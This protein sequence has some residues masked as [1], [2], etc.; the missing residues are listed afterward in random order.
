MS[1][2]F[3]KKH[4]LFI[5]KLKSLSSAFYVIV[6]VGSNTHTKKQQHKNTIKLIIMKKNQIITTNGGLSKMKLNINNIKYHKITKQCKVNVES[7]ISIST[8]GLVVFLNKLLTTNNQT[9][10]YNQ[11][12]S[13][14]QPIKL[15]FTTNQT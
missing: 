13:S 11:S 15:L 7:N 4:T 5:N 2:F 3:L 6:E 14:L 1:N 12:N 8:S 10:L 9:P